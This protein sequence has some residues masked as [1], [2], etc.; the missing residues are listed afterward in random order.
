MHNNHIFRILK[1]QKTSARG[2]HKSCIYLSVGKVHLHKIELNI[3][4]SWLDIF[5]WFPLCWTRCWKS[6]ETLLLWLLRWRQRL[7]DG[8][9]QATTS[10]FLSRWMCTKNDY[11]FIIQVSNHDKETNIPMKSQKPSLQFDFEIKLNTSTVCLYE[12]RD[13]FIIFL[14]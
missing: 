13:I 3:T 11:K 1:C 9:H 10:G 8:R 6:L 14:L 7:P 2:T 5:K 4:T 12:K